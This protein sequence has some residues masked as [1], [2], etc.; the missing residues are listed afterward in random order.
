M[1]SSPKRAKTDFS[2]TPISVRIEEEE[3]EP[4][5]EEYEIRPSSDNAFSVKLVSKSGDN[6]ILSSRPKHFSCSLCDLTFPVKQLLDI[7]LKNHEE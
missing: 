4:T 7:H 2:G 3:E 5:L 6:D 1:E